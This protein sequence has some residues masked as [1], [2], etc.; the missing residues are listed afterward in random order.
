MYAPQ[1]ICEP[2]NVNELRKWAINELLNDATWQRKSI[3]TCR[4]SKKNTQ[5]S[6]GP[7]VSPTR[8]RVEFKQ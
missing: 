8:V 2:V 1:N 6:E 7:G 4:L 3:H 5:A